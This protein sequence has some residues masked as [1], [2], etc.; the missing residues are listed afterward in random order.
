MLRDE[1][2][3]WD[4]LVPSSEKGV[5]PLCAVY[6]KKCIPAIAQ[7]LEQ[8]R[9]V[10]FY[11]LVRVRILPKETIRQVDPRGLSFLNVNTR[12]DYERLVRMHELNGRNS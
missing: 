4:A 12:Q 3:G 9:I 2:D 5:E 7:V 10:A 8:R 6:T 11:P 1:S